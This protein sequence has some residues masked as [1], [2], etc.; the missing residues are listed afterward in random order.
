MSIITVCSHCG[1]Q[2]KGEAN[3]FCKDCNTVE[4]RNQMDANNKK[5]WDDTREGENGGYKNEKL[6]EYECKYCSKKDKDENTT[7]DN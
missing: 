2:R 5:V 3:K 1:E 4:K 7:G 6:P